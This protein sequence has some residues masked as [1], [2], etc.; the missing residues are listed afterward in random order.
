[1]SLLDKV[2]GPSNQWK[3]DP[4]HKVEWQTDYG[5]GDF[6][7]GLEDA[8]SGFGRKINIFFRTAEVINLSIG[9]FIK[10]KLFGLKTNK[11]YLAKLSLLLEEEFDAYLLDTNA[12]KELKE[13]YANVK[14][15][16]S[17]YNPL[18]NHEAYVA[19]A[20]KKSITE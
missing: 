12:N 2:F 18:Y 5:N 16:G 15:L 19:E 3:M 1:M 8:L 4:N 14:F 10:Q 7:K 6:S 11:D 9:M 13:E 17:S 20:K